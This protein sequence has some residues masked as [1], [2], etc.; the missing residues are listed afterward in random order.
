MVGELEQKLVTARFTRTL[1]LLLVHGLEHVQIRARFQPF[2]PIVRFAFRRQQQD[3]HAAG[4]AQRTGKGNAILARHHHV[5]HQKIE[6][7]PRQD[8][9][10]M[11]DIAGGRDQKAVSHEEFLQECPDT[12]VIVDDQQMRVEVIHQPLSLS[13]L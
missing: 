3:R 4:L 7:Q 12:L 1:G 2:D 8:A 5:Q 11:R 9:P 13:L 6:L 10:R